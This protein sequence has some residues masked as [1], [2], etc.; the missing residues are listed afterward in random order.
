MD[1]NP[2]ER[3]YKI[4]DLCLKSDGSTVK[5]QLIRIFSLKQNDK[6]SLFSC[7]L[8]INNLIQEVKLAIE[9]NPELNKEIYLSPFPALISAFDIF[10]FD[11]SWNDTIRKHIT[12]EV[13]IRLEYIKD[14]LSKIHFEKNIEATNIKEIIK[15]IDNLYDQI[16]KSDLHKK[17]KTII[18]DMLISM[19]RAIN[20]YQIGGAKRLRDVLN[21]IITK[22]LSDKDL[23]NESKDK[24]EVKAFGII[25]SKI[26][27]MVT[28]AVNYYTLFNAAKENITVLLEYIKK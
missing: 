24:E 2:A 21:E 20:E 5:E 15:E 27:Y 18:L 17:L 10:N 23:F 25:I 11:A 9:E 3:L 6:T 8:Q 22:L 19:R 14:G 1:N 28:N 26:N 16:N 4:V 7:I 13:K 12:S